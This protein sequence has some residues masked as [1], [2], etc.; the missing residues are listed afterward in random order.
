MSASTRRLQYAALLTSQTC[1]STYG[2]GCVLYAVVDRELQIL[3]SAGRDSY[4]S[5]RGAR[6]FTSGPDGG[7]NSPSAGRRSFPGEAIG[8]R[9]FP[10]LAIREISRRGV[11]NLTLSAR[12]RRGLR[13][14]RDASQICMSRT[15]PSET[16]CSQQEQQCLE[17][18]GATRMRD[19]CS[20]VG[21]RRANT[22]PLL[23]RCGVCCSLPTTCVDHGWTKDACYI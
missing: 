16:H 7:R 19:H 20:R 12:R 22:S 9:E 13:A 18:H 1:S 15:A 10:R 17:F 6:S 14:H 4:G 11:A 21:V 3:R 23:L 2:R 5:S 8:L